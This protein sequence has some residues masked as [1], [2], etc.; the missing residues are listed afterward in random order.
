MWILFQMRYTI[1]NNKYQ[2]ASHCM[3]AA[4]VEEGFK[5]MEWAHLWIHIL[6]FLVVVVVLYGI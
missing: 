4:S 5:I 6:Y 1:K 3:K 2:Q